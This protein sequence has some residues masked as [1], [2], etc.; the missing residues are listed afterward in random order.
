MRFEV[1]GPLRVTDGGRELPITR[2]KLCELVTTLA[3]AW[4]KP[5]QGTYVDPERLAE[6][7]W[8]DP[9]GK[10]P[11]L[12]NHITLARSKL[13]DDRVILHRQRGY[14]LVLNADEDTLDL[15]E[16]L[17]SAEQG[18]VAAGR[19][20]NIHA[21]DHF[22]RAIALWP[23]DRPLHDFPG[24]LPM[25]DE[26][27]NRLRETYAAARH[28][29]LEQ[30]M[31]LGACYE[32]LPELEA[33]VVKEPLDERWWSLLM[34]ARRRESGRDS[35]LRVFARA[36]KVFEIEGM[37][38]AEDLLVA[39]DRIQAGDGELL[40][41]A[42]ARA[43]QVPRTPAVPDQLSDGPDTEIDQRMEDRVAALERE[44]AKLREELDRDRSRNREII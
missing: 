10:L 24:T 11:S 7:I 41:A 17:K 30:Q 40:P 2:R 31:A 13:G 20:D 28:A 9:S 16:F 29:C 39:R 26:V 25:Q 43:L 34:E 36:Q 6:L 44:V 12:R 15:A 32:V 37:E 35:A 38:L 4:T 18:H 22:L 1:L 19:G 42:S 27:T 14:Q 23:D 5:G 3:A 21:R 33:L 8:A